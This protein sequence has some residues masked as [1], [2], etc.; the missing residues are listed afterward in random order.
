M[1]SSKASIKSFKDLRI[2]SLLPSTTDICIAL[3]LQNNVV[4]ITHECDFPLPDDSSKSSPFKHHFV[5]CQAAIQNDPA[6]TIAKK[7]L[8]LTVSHIDP[9]KA[10]QAEIDLA[11]KTSLHDGLSLYN[12][13]DD[14][15]SQAQPDIIL[16]QSLC[17]V[18]AVAKDEVDD[19]VSC[20]LPPNQCQVLSL[21]PESLEEVTETF[22]R[23]ADACG[24][25]ERGEELRR[26]FWEGAERVLL[27]TKKSGIVKT[28]EALP[29]LLFLEWV[30]P[31]FNGGHWIPDMVEKWSGCRTA[32]SWVTNTCKSVQLSWQQIY[33]ADPDLVVIACCGFDLKRNEKDAL[34]ARELLKPL[35]AF[36]QG[37]I[38][39]ADG[40]LYFA[41]PGPALREGIAILSRCAYDG[42]KDVVNELEGL[43]WL[44]NV[45]EGWARVVYD[46]EAVDPS[47]ADMED[48]ITEKNEH[49]F[50]K[51]H[52]QAC[53]EGKDVYIDPKTG[54]SVFT[55]IAHKK[56]GKCC[57]SGCRHCPYNHINVKDKANK[58]QQPAFLYEGP[59]K[60]YDEQHL[61]AS[62]PTIPPNSHIKVLF[63]SGGKDSFLTIR[64]LVKEKLQNEQDPF[65]LI[66]LTTFDSST[67]VIAHQE[68]PIET[69]LKQAQHLEIPLLAIPLS[70][71]SGETYLSRIQSGLN[72]IQSRVPDISK[73]T[74]V[75]G[76][77]HLDHIREWRE[78]ELGQYPLEYPLWKVSYDDLMDDLEK[79]KIRVVLSAATK[80]GVKEGTVFTRNFRN[81]VE[82]LG[83]DGFGE[84]GEF[85]SVAEVW[86][87]SRK[88]ALGL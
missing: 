84:N 87:A 80:D 56:R 21:E 1:T 42:D 60:S 47:I 41:R 35:R 67:R 58:I 31:P 70:R 33:D 62:I 22:V 53:A 36:K 10:T 82:A 27:A 8:T 7:P 68:I 13:N 77:L 19:K 9:S 23:I 69:V 50:A 29:K 63:H 34:A 83:M 49:T 72:A 85:H 66:L 5:I 11:V 18:C 12:L 79:S 54:Y 39:A 46:Q 64:K 17:E 24:V 86:A 28:K 75:F 30:D 6:A 44:P 32:T 51:L 57:G 43:G 59:E 40:N 37:R 4:G 2:A 55:E 65:H 52:E 88:E 48:L 45:G 16:T 3:G 25:P 26:S 20:R 38:Y 15:L 73:L 78:K 71:C 81:V 61:F 76:D 14:A 74:L